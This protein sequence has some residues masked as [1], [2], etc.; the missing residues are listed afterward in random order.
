MGYT[1][2]RLKLATEG[3]SRTQAQMNEALEEPLEF[4]YGE[5]AAPVPNPTLAP[6]AVEA[7]PVPAPAAP[8]A[9]P[10]AP[11]APQVAP[12][13]AA[14]APVASPAPTPL[15]A[16]AGAPPVGVPGGKRTENGYSFYLTPLD[17]DDWF[18][19]NPDATVTV[20]KYADFEC[21]FCQYFAQQAKPVMEKYKDR[22]RFVMK[23]YPMNPQCNPY[24]Q[25]YDKHPNACHASL[26]AICAGRQGKF[27]EMHEKLYAVA[28]NLDPA[29][30]R[31]AAGELGLDLAAFDACLTD[32]ATKTRIDRDIEIAK[33]AA[34]YGT[35]RTFVNGRL[36]TGANSAE[37]LEYYIVKA[38][39]NAPG[40][41][42]LQQAQAAPTEAPAQG[43]MVEARR[44]GGA[45]FIDSHEASVT[46]DGRAL[47]LPGKVPAMV[48]FDEA[49]SACQKAGKRLCTE[50][51]W[52]SACTGQPALDDNTNGWFND[53]TIE[54]NMY[55]YG[56][57]Y[58]VG[59]C[60]DEGEKSKA[61]PVATGSK[62]ACRTATGVFDLTGNINEWVSTTS[63]KPSLM[64][65]GAS[66]GSGATCNRRTAT[67]G[68]GYRNQTTGFRCCA[69]QL[70][71]QE[72]PEQDQLAAAR[73]PEV[74]SPV[75]L[76]KAADSKGAQVDLAAFKGKVLVVNFFAS[77]CGP[78]KKEFPVL[79]E[80]HKDFGAKGLEI[81]SVGVDGMAQQ[82][83][84]FAAQF[85]PTF[86]IVP[87]PES[88]LMGTYNVY[89]M[90]ATFIVDREG[91]I[92]F[93]GDE[94]SPEV[95]L[96]KLKTTV[97]ELVGG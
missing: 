81:V 25:G 39:E 22:V 83:I 18:Y 4:H 24:M 3:L 70:V 2:L 78:C 76:F 29:A 21:A 80:L 91:I 33:R 57:F 27:W 12:T 95:H 77:W 55:A 94:F 86:A 64:G 72:A 87:D 13:T 93:K 44:S 65:G 28:P 85:Q 32:P 75:P 79:V 14:A 48:S 9:M 43:T 5:A 19:G 10:T 92:R 49:N 63:G 61:E 50:E 20:V 60:H 42:S 46:T 40:F 54:G 52:V 96:E 73:K 16:P 26:A 59:H 41:Y 62:P 88:L 36:L 45:F 31:R 1:G 71:A 6:A 35:P 97:R 11:A 17:S 90:P 34:I 74:G 15:P 23:Q 47:V 38:L 66:A 56:P 69:D 30:N 84:D 37:A 68:S 7:A 89:S 53:D 67:F 58:E 8:V 51:E 82:S